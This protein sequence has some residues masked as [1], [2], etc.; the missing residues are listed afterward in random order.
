[1]QDL[2]I[3]RNLHWRYEWVR[4]LPVDVYDVLVEELNKQHR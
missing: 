1:V 3:A 4:G 2:A